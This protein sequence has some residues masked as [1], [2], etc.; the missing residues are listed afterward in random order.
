MTMNDLRKPIAI[1]FGILGIVLVSMPGARAPLT[2]AP[3]NLYAG[4]SML[5]FAGAM[6]WLAFRKS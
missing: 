5:I 2:D 1:F 4:I 3:V 6:A